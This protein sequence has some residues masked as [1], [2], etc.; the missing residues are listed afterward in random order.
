MSITRD[1][2]QL[3]IDRL[4]DAFGDRAFSEQRKHMIWES[5]AGLEYKAVIAV[6]DNFIRSSKYAPLPA[7]F[8]TATEG[9]GRDGRRALGAYSDN[10]ACG[11]CHDSGFV[12]VR[13]I[14]GHEEWART[15]SGSAACHCGRGREVLFRLANLPKNPVDL[16]SQWNQRW[17]KSYRI[18][19]RG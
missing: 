13:R 10:P 17:E 4:E 18:V 5:V 8:S 19:G 9:M 2:F 15:E 16:K 3:Q 6:V 11:D 14:E 1:Q 7:D 12:S